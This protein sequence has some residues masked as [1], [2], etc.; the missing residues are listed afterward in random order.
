MA[1]EY[2]VCALILQS[3]F[4]SITD[5]AHYHYPWLMLNP[6]DSYNSL[7]RIQQINAPLLLI[8]GQKDLIVP[9]PTRINFI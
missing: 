4:T 2:K 1:L 7:E 9:P 6:W 5:V 3:P 8:H